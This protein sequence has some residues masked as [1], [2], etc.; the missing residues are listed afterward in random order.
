MQRIQSAISG[1]FDAAGG[2]EVIQAV[3][4]LVRSQSELNALAEGGGVKNFTAIPDVRDDT[5][6]RFAAGRFRKTFRSLRPLLDNRGEPDKLTR[7]STEAAGLPFRRA[8]LSQVELDD[9][10]RGFALGLI[11]TWVRNPSHVRLLRVA[12]DLW[13]TPQI[14]E[15][16]LRLFEPYLSGKARGAARRVAFYCLSELFRAGATE[17]G[18][19]ADVETLPDKIDLD[20]YRKTLAAAALRI[21][22]S[23]AATAYPWYLRQQ[24]LLF[25]AVYSPAQ[26]PVGRRVPP[27]ILANYWRMLRFLEGRI[28]DDDPA[29]YAKQAVVARRSFLSKADAAELVGPQLTSLRFAEIASRD[30]EFAREL[31]AINRPDL[32]QGSTLAND[33]GVSD[34]TQPDGTA[35]LKDLV[36]AKGNRNVLRNEI[37]IISFAIAFLKQVVGRTPIPAVVTPSSLQI[38][39]AEQ[40]GFAR[41]ID[42]SFQATPMGDGY[43]S[44]YSTPSWASQDEFWRFQ[45]GFLLR[46]I[47]TGK[48]DFSTT[49]KPQS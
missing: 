6:G 36:S 3:Q 12:V 13:P 4:G 15:E 26:V 19:V 25:L 42:V 38:T 27:G 34:W 20:G 16:V 49:T 44:I 46:F 48:V 21:V 28:D 47:L 14:L 37:G 43:R 41:V 8:R 10:A 33:L 39:Y 31:Y 30:L 22:K 29:I 9:E 2:E 40:K 18:I 17:T 32:P 23:K 35:I 11:N 1:G 45:L 7:Q 5:I 24:A